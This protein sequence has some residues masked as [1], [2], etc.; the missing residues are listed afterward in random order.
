MLLH[1]IMQLNDIQGWGSISLNPWMLLHA[2]QSANHFNMHHRVA[3]DQITIIGS[4]LRTCF[5]LFPKH[6]RPC[7][8]RH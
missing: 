4:C 3:R 6:L 7:R 2:G 8:H 5:L 1:V